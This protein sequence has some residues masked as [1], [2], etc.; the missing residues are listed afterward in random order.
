[1]CAGRAL[2]CA[3]GLC[4]GPS[5]GQ[6]SGFRRGAWAQQ[7]V[8]GGSSATDADLLLGVEDPGRRGP[9][10]GPG[11]QGPPAPERPALLPPPLRLGRVTTEG[12]LSLR[13]SPAP[14]SPNPAATG[15]R[16]CVGRKG[17]ET[18]GKQTWTE[19]TWTGAGASGSAALETPLALSARPERASIAQSRGSPTLSALGG[20]PAASEEAQGTRA[21]AGMA[22][23]PHGAEARHGRLA[24]WA[25]ILPR[26]S[27][28]P[29]DGSVWCA[30]TARS[31]HR[32]PA[33]IHARDGV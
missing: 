20:P 17:K 21:S 7:P 14:F 30:P 10:S 12:A 28:V 11:A 13:P 2:A 18:S 23:R 15:T 8:W 3:W 27:S 19:F 33:V 25:Q 22:A 26:R 24:A 5:G 9:Q 1:M 16:A 6:D 31:P 32:P 4:P 29:S